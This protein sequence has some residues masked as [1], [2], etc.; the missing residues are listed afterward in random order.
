MKDVEEKALTIASEYTGL[1]KNTLKLL[2]SFNDKLK[3]VVSVIIMAIDI[4]LDLEE[5]SN[6]T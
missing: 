1:N 5:L 4:I 6:D 3:R 2:R